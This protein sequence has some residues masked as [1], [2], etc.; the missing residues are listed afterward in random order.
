MPP[1]PS[2][3]PPFSHTY[4]AYTYTHS[5]L[6]LFV[7]RDCVEYQLLGKFWHD[8]QV[9]CASSTRPTSVFSTV[10]FA[11]NETRRG[12]RNCP[13]SRSVL[14]PKVYLY[15]L[16]LDGTSLWVWKFCRYSRIIVVISAVVTT[17]C[18]VDCID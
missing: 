3:P 18:E 16:L 8:F 17:I 15:V 6:Y 10:N 13:Y 9:K 2:P 14:I 11:Y 12:V 1:S 4:Y 5:S 7:Q